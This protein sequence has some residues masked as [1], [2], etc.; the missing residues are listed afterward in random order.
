VVEER[1]V[2]DPIGSR[3]DEIEA[4]LARPNDQRVF[5]I[6]YAFKAGCRSKQIFELTNIDPVVP[7]S[8]C[9]S[10]DRRR[11]PPRAA[12][13]MRRLTIRKYGQAHGFSDQATGLLVGS[14][15]PRWTSGA[16]GKEL[17]GFATFKQVDTCA[18]EFEAYTPYYYSTYEDRR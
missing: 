18:A 8:I 9:N 7:R 15:R 2:G 16:T 4:K 13:G 1:P 3:L 5:Y 17:G 12:L 11:D 14:Q 6:R 10:S